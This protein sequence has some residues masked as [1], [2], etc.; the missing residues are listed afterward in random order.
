MAKTVYALL[1]GIDKY[2]DPVPALNGCVNDVLAADVVLRQ[3]A[4]GATY[5]PLILKDDQATRQNIID[6]FRQHLAQARSD[7]VALFYYSGHGSQEDAPPEFWPFEPD[8]LDE[9]L[10]CYDSRSPGSFDLADKELGALIAEV[11]ANGTHVVIILDCCHSGTA[12]RAALQPDVRIRRAPTDHRPRPLS[13]FLVQPSALPPSTRSTKKQTVDWVDLPDG[14][15]VVLSACRADETAKEYRIE[16]NVRGAFS[17]FLQDALVKAGPSVTYRDL[18]KRVYTLVRNNVAEQTPQVE[19]SGGDIE[20]PF[21][22]GAVG[23][24]NQYLT[25]SHDSDGWT[26]DA[27]AVHGIPA[28]HDDETTTLAIFLGQH[29]QSIARSQ[30]SAWH[31]E[32]DRCSATAKHG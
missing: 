2:A 20:Q 8:K 10:V 17:Y 5:Q 28:P 31:S 14:K 9:T 11:A 7:D 29:W 22:G 30:R 25:L 3:R 24:R 12:T 27:G 32:G 26:I 15:H 21:L 6:G 1:V 18:F 19:A 16:G 23:A 13:S 4:V